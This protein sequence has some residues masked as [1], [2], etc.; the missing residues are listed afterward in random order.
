MG[1]LGLTVIDKAALTA[2]DVGNPDDL[3]STNQLAQWFGC[4]PQWL[5]IAR[6]QGSGP[7]YVV[8]G[9][10]KIRYSRGAVRA[11]IVAQSHNSTSEYETVHGPGRPRVAEAGDAAS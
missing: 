3:L 2:A 11:W 6:S 7:P 5:N 1:V 8:L 10:K 4:S 9:P